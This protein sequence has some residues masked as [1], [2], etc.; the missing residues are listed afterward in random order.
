L[1]D[2]LLFW[3]PILIILNVDGGSYFRFCLLSSMCVCRGM[4]VCFTYTCCS[5]RDRP[6]IRVVVLFKW[7]RSSMGFALVVLFKW[8][9]SS[10]DFALVVLFKWLMSSMDLVL[11][12]LFKWLMSSM[13]LVLV[14]LFK[15]LRSSMGFA[16]VVLFKWL[17]SSLRL[18][19]YSSSQG[20]L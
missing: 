7:L 4:L 13:D 8:L 18:L 15:W 10:M 19:F 12:V 20:C 14:V 9:M 11:V 3:Q 2:V 17:M 16:L 5:V 1:N 6:N